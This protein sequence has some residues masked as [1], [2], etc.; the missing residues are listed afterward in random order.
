MP[1]PSDKQELSPR[2]T[3]HH[4]GVKINMRKECIEIDEY[5]RDMKRWNLDV[6]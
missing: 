5:Q 4:P 2:F 6:G 3:S 1:K